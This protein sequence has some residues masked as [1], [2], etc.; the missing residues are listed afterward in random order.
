MD[1]EQFT[2]EY[3]LSKRTA[4]K[5]TIHRVPITEARRHPGSL[6]RRL[7]HKGE[8]FI[9]E[10][11]GIPVAAVMDP[12]ELDD[13]LDLQDSNIRRMMDEGKAEHRA[14]K[15]RPARELLAE[16]RTQPAR[17]GRSRRQP[18]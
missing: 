5:P 15:T 3:L 4:T 1:I 10:K 6:V 14:G 2:K 7:H 16:L 18:V 17:P 13:Y 9:L 8:Y 12:D 11:D